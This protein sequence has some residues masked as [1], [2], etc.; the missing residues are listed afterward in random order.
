MWKEYTK[1]DFL[2]KMERTAILDKNKRKLDSQKKNSNGPTNEED[3]VIEINISISQISRTKSLII[4][5]WTIC[6][7]S[8]VF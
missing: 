7:L 2:Q 4:M 8:L 3:Q 1:L 6:W 5:Y